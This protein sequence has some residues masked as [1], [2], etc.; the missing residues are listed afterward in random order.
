MNILFVCTGNTCRSPLAETIA[1]AMIAERGIPDMHV[2]SA[3][4]FALPDAPASD[5]SLAVGKEHGHDLSSHRARETTAAVVQWAD[6]I[7]G[8]GP[9]HLERVADLGGEGKSELLASFASRG[10]DSRGVSDPFGSGIDV[11]RATYDELAREIGNALD[12]LVDDR[13]QSQA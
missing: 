5:G 13:S 9:H 12:R 11:Y 3:G 10:A 4:T 7:L 1:R 8:M 6:L 2:G